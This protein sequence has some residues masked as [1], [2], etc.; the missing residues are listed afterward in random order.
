MKKKYFY[1]SNCINCGS[2]INKASTRC[3]TC[4]NEQ[5]KTEKKH[6][7][8]VCCNKEIGHNS[9]VYG[10]GHCRSCSK[11]I[12]IDKDIL[13][14]KYNAEMK[15]I[16]AIAKELNCNYVSIYN[17]LN[18]Y[19]IPIRSKRDS[20]LGKKRP[21]HSKLMTGENNPNF[22]NWSSLEPYTFEFNKKF[23]EEI[24]ERDLRLCQLCFKSE[25]QE[26]QDLNRKLNIHHIDYNKKNCSKYNLISLCESCHCKSNFKREHWTQFFKNLLFSK[27]IYE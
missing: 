3:R 16:T 7:F 27:G 24:R 8:C 9:A 22:R 6:Y 5:L 26:Q 23:K 25:K 20:H 19:Q 10:K 1:Y 21:D 2:Q 4:A 13:I 17:K 12:F 18:L 15:S 14:Y 11:T